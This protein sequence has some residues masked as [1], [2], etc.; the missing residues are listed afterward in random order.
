LGAETSRKNAVALEP[1][2]IPKG[3]AQPKTCPKLIGNK[4]QKYRVE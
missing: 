3:D 4:R 1:E 2:T